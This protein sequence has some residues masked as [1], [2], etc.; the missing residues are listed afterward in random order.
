MAHIGRHPVGERGRHRVDVVPCL[1]LIPADV[2]DRRRCRSSDASG[3]LD[4]SRSRADR[5]GQVRRCPPASS[6]VAN[7]LPPSSDF[8]TGRP[9]DVYRLVVRRIDAELTEVHR[10]RVTVADERPRRALVVG[11]EQA[12][13]CG[14]E[15]RMPRRLV[16][17]TA[18]AASRPGVVAPVVAASAPTATKPPPPPP[19]PPAAACCCGFAPRAPA[20]GA[21]PPGGV[22]AAAP[23]GVASVLAFGSAPR[24]GAGA[25]SDPPQSARR[26]RSGFDRDT[27]SAIRP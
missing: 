14:I 25:R 12:T 15:R 7:V 26:R 24:A 5:R 13:A 6:S 22:T 21:A 20:A 23:G 19:P 11:S 17:P 3:S 4:R 9:G 1:A 27:S 18:E 8:A 10:T 2:R 16:P